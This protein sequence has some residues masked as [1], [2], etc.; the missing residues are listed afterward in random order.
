ME[1]QLNNETEKG[2]NAKFFSKRNLILLVV[3]VIL[4]AILLWLWWK[5]PMSFIRQT[6]VYLLFG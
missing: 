2:V 6:L 1:V 4:G 5:N 3:Y